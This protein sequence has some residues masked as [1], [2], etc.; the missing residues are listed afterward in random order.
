MMAAP[1]GGRF[2]FGG[3]EESGADGLAAIGFENIERND[4][5]EFARASP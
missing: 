5:G 2:P 3:F 4:V 1:R